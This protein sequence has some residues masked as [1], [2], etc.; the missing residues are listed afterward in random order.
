MRLQIECTNSDLMRDAVPLIGRMHDA[1]IWRLSFVKRHLRQLLTD[2]EIVAIMMYTNDI[3]RVWEEGIDDPAAYVQLYATYNGMCRNLTMMTAE[4]Q[5]IEWATWHC[6]SYNL[7]MGLLKLP[8]FRDDHPLFRA[9]RV[10]QMGGQRLLC[11]KLRGNGLFYWKQVSS[12]SLCI[13]SR[14]ITVKAAMALS[15]VS[16]FIQISM[17]L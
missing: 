13:K 14:S 15:A 8:V 7:T 6:F 10:G 4:K 17:G 5:W 11:S 1:V 2:D 12:C 3:T 16:V 9:L